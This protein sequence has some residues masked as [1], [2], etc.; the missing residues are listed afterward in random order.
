MWC[1][2]VCMRDI[3]KIRGM[4]NVESVSRGEALNGLR[5]DR[6]PR[7]KMASFLPSILPSVQLV[8]TLFLGLAPDKS[9]GSIYSP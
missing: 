1:P 6:H 4:A 5:S 8:T 2:A 7:Q 3:P 9:D